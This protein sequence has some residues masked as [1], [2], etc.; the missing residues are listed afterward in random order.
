MNLDTKYPEVKVRLTGRDGNAMVIITAVRAALRHN[1]PPE[2][3]DAF[4]D[5]AMSGDYDHVLQTAMRW[6]DVS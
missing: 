2:E 5:E 6:V 3:L 1:A 4:T